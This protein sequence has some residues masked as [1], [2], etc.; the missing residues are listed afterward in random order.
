MTETRITK[1]KAKGLVS[2]FLD[3]HGLQYA[4]LSAKTVG[5]A[6]LARGEAIFV[7]VHG[8]TP[9]PKWSEL[10]QLARENGFFVEAEM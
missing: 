8:W 9:S 5:F 2:A 6:D 10:K 3:E 4:R 7:C 1:G